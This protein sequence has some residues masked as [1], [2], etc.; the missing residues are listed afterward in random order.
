MFEAFAIT[1]G[2]SVLPGIDLST[3]DENGCEEVVSTQQF[4]TEDGCNVW[5]D[6]AL[7]SWEYNV[8]QYNLVNGTKIFVK[9]SGCRPVETE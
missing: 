6:R 7:A 9:D 5:N 4:L 8:S 2:L 3:I 1:C